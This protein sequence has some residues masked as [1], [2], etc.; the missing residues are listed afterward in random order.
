MPTKSKTTD[1]NKCIECN[2]NKGTV[3]SI[4]KKR[5]C[6]TCAELPQY[7]MISRTKSKR[8]YKLT[9]GDLTTIQMYEWT[10]KYGICNYYT[11][12]DVE[13]IAA[14]K[15]GAPANEVKSVI[16]QIRQDRMKRC[17]E[18]KEKRMRLRSD[19]LKQALNQMGVQLRSDS[20]YC[21]GYI[22]GDVKDPID[23]IVNRMCQMKYLYEY[24]NMDE[25]KEEV[26]LSYKDEY[27]EP[28]EISD[29]AERLALERYSNGKFPKIFPWLNK[30]GIK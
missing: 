17:T 4:L 10:N 13:T 28:F 12:L 19:M 26:Y 16:E 6:A 14:K 23:T 1:S 25:C 20:T 11:M 22:N 5:L 30:E 9:D 24:C 18:T 21:K 27:I 15:H 3:R 2:K 29:E 7:T 8:D